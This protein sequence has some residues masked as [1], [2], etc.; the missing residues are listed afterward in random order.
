M[1]NKFF[2]VKPEVPGGLGEN[3]VF[4]KSE[5]PWKIISVHLVFDGW[6][7]ANVVKVSP[8]FFVTE[9]LRNRIESENLSGVINFEEIQISTSETFKELMPNTKIP[10]FFLMRIN[11]VPQKDDIGTTSNFKLILSEKALAIFREYE[12]GDFEIEEINS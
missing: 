12:L 7:G 5:V 4:D 11:G 3:T 1:D 2:L 9:M 6:D 10:S 8:C